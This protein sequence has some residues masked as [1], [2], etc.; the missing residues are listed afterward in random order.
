MVAPGGRRVTFEDCEVDDVLEAG[1]KSL[2]SP[3][4]D[5]RRWVQGFSASLSCCL[6]ATCSMVMILTNKWL[7]SSFD[8]QAYVSLLVMQNVIATALM[9]GCKAL[10][11]VQY[12]Y[13]DRR[14]AAAWFPVTSFFVLMLLTSF[15]AMRYLS[16]PMITVFK[17]L[18]NLLTVAG[19]WYFFGKPL[20]LGVI[21]AFV[22]MIVGAVLAAYNDLTFSMHGYV[23]QIANCVAASGY[24]LSLKH[25][26]RHVQLSRFGMVFY[27]NIMTFPLL[28][29]IA[30]ANGEPTALQEAR[31]RGLL[32]LRFFLWNALAGCVSFVLSLASVWCVATTSATTYSVV[33]ALNKVPVTVLGFFLFRAPI[34]SEAGFYIGLSLLGGFLYSWEKIRH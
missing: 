13:F 5:K 24:V 32:D 29:T 26:T 14:I 7:A 8:V 20:T 6:Y 3:S 31:L 1:D 10:G 12:P 19:E 23:W 4:V 25:A 28:F 27:N 11:V 9:I 17:Q 15:V 18:A 21:A 33:G 22:V 34:S 16:V 2:L 30:C